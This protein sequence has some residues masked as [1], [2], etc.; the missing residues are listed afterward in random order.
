MG[1]Q[2]AQV[3]EATAHWLVFEPFEFRARLAQ[4]PA[5]LRVLPVQL[6]LRGGCDV[7]S[8]AMA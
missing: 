6:A 4:L 7:S 5:L 1:V 2:S 8:S 3:R